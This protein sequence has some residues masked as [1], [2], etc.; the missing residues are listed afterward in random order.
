[1]SRWIKL[2]GHQAEQRSELLIEN[3]TLNSDAIY[4]LYQNR[5]NTKILMIE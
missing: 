4:R 5:D 2:M 1:M 3:G